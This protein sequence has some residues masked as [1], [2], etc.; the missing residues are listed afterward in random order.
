MSFRTDI[1][2]IIDGVAADNIELLLGNRYDCYLVNVSGITV[3]PDTGRETGTKAETKT[4]LVLLS[5]K[6]KDVNDYS[7]ATPH[8]V[9]D[10]RIKI[11]QSIT[12]T[13]IRAADYIELNNEVYKLANGPLEEDN[14]GLYW[15][16]T[17][18]KQ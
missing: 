16:I 1:L 17:L 6:V 18:L 3:D 4:K 9:G 11:S 10:A 5:L 2:D 13:Q 15:W 8:K 12:E 7:G 14:G